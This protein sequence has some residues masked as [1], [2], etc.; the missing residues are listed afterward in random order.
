LHVI[1]VY[2]DV[3]PPVAGGIEKHIDLI[4]R[5]LPD[6]RSDVLVCARGRH[7]RRQPY[8][9]GVEVHVA[10]LGPRVWSVPIA[11]AFPFSLRRMQADV[12]HLHMPNPLGE[13]GVLMDRKRPVVCTYHADVVRQARVTAIYRPLVHACLGRA[14]EIIVGS[15]RLRETSPFLGVHASRANVIPYFVDTEHYAPSRVSDSDRARLRA[16]YSGPIVLA[17]ARLV[18]YKGLEILIEAAQ[19][20]KASVVIIGDGPLAGRLHGLAAA[21]PNVHFAGRVNEADLLCHLAAADC[22]VLPSTSRAEAFGIAVM[23]AQAM[24]VPAV[25]TD[26][27]TGTAEAIVPGE[28]GLVVQPGDAAALAAGI[29]D[30]LSDPLRRATMGRRARERAVALHSASRAADQLRDI[31]ERAVAAGASSTEASV[32]S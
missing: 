23:E 30:I 32:Q 18:Y 14:A 21:S 1:H 22:F 4:R 11:P 26:V 6:V 2:N 25:V 3:F 29:N 17:V 24:A 31:Y 20:L 27:G 12:I 7:S 13:L 28:T 9:T 19:S 8:G 15:R 5:A 10:E 16:R